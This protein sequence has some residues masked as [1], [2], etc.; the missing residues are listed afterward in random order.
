MNRVNGGSS[1]EINKFENQS[2]RKIWYQYWDRIIRDER[3]YYT[4]LNYIHQNPIK[5]GLVKTL[6]ELANYQ[7]CSYKNYL[8]KFG[9]EWLDD[10]FEQYPVVSFIKS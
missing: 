6:D 8:L 9:S 4:H 3:D 5:H 7:F 2:G 1:Y 10:C